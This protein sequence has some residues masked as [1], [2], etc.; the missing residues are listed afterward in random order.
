LGEPKEIN[1]KEFRDFGYLQEVNRRFF[2]PLGLALI[3]DCDGEDENQAHLAIQDFRHLNEGQRFPEALISIQKAE[4]IQDELEMREGYRI[5]A[6]GW[7]QQPA[8]LP[9]C[10]RAEDDD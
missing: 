7:A 4:R 9:G 1:L 8:C 6:M 3:M 5:Q 10:L 2:H